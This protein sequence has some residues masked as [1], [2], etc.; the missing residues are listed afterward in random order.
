MVGMLLRSDHLCHN[1]ACIVEAGIRGSSHAFPTPGQRP[2]GS[3]VLACLD[4]RHRSIRER[5]NQRS[6]SLENTV[7][8]CGNARCVE[9]VI[10]WSVV[11]NQVDD[12]LQY[13]G[14]NASPPW[15]SQRIPHLAVAHNRR[16]QVRLCDDRSVPRAARKQ[17][18]PAV[19]QHPTVPRQEPG[20]KPDGSMRECHGHKHSLAI[21]HTKM[22]RLAR[23][24][25]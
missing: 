17:I 14:W 22:R 24:T 7:C 9:D 11:M 2:C 3:K 5:L 16:R 4:A 19:E 20:A 23:R 15:R 21:A 13:D 1:H 25:G 10:D 18:G 12:G 8:S 6:L